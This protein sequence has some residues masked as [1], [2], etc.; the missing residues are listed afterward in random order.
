MDNFMK[1]ILSRVLSEEIGRQEHW[2]QQEIEYRLS[3]ALERDDNIERIKKFMEENGIEI[4][5][6]YMI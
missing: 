3:S 1:S 6:E 2:K 5:T 4:K